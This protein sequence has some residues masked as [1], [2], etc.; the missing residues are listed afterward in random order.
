MIRAISLAAVFMA[1]NCYAFPFPFPMPL[2]EHCDGN[3]VVPGPMSQYES[4]NLSIDFIYEDND[5]T[6]DPNVPAITTM[7]LPM[8]FGTAD[9]GFTIPLID[10]NNAATYG[11]DWQ[12]IFDW[13]LMY[14]PD[15]FLRFNFD[16]PVG[17]IRMYGL[18]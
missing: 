2:T 10:E 3:G 14:P 8:S 17:L 13:G 11:L 9:E 16:T 12:A 6:H 4:L 1:T 15:R 5:G 18:I 7:T